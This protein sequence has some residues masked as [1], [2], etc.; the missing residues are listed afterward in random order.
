MAKTEKNPPT[1][2]PDSFRLAKRSM[3]TKRN[4]GSY[5]PKWS[6]EEVPGVYSYNKT[7][8]RA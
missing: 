3:Q 5:H 4:P 2:L 1:K 8:N 7:L 6:E